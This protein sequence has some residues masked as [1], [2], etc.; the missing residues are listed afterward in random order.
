MSSL[1]KIC[2]TLAVMSNFA[3][4]YGKY[5]STSTQY[6]NYSL[7]SP[8]IASIFIPQSLNAFPMGLHLKHR[9]ID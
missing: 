4:G 7:L 5:Y 3:A 9:K 2:V 1:P 8:A 6:Y